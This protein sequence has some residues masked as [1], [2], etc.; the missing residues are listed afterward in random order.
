MVAVITGG[1]SGLGLC[2]ARVLDAN[3]AKAVYIVGR[4]QNTLDDAAKTAFNGK[5]IPIVLQAAL[6]KPEMPG[7][8]NAFHVNCTAAFYIIVAFLDLLDAGTKKHNLP[9]DAQI[10]VT[11]SVAA[12]SRNLASSFAYSASKAAIN[13]LAKMINMIVPSIHPSEMTRGS[14][15]SYDQFSGIQGHE[16]H[17]TDARNMT[18]DKVPAERSG[19]E[20]DFAGA[21]L[22][23][24]V[25]PACLQVLI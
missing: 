13:H 20:E 19:S 17:F 6:W 3:G 24:Q 11:S 8:S 10:L 16:Q 5:I 12:F 21:I 7:F 25:V 18:A 1:G 23:Q 4:R 22:Y 2:A 9:S 15:A 14:M